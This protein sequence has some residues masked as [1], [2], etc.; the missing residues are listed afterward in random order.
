MFNYFQSVRS[1]SQVIG[2]IPV[3]DYL[4]KIRYGDEYLDKIIQAREVYNENKEIYNSIKTNELPCYTLN[5]TFDGTRKN[6]S[7][8][9]STGYVYLDIDGCTEFDF[10]NPIV[11]A[12]WKSLSNNGRGVLVKAEGIEP[13]NFRYAYKEIA[14]EIGIEA[15]IGANKASQPNVLSFDPNI[16]LN[17]NST[18]YELSYLGNEKNTHFSNNRIEKRTIGTETGSTFEH[19]RYDNLDELIQ[20][21]EYNDEVIY[22]YGCKIKYAD[23]YIPFG[24]FK[25]GGRNTG[26]CGYGYQLKN[27]NPNISMGVLL[28]ML[29]AANKKYCHP[30]LGYTQLSQIVKSI[31]NS[32]TVQPKFNKTRRFL[33][34]PDYDLSTREKRQLMAKKIGQDKIAKSKKKIEKAIR[35]WDFEKYGK[36]TQKGLTKTSGLNIKTVQKY[37]YL[38]KP[39]IQF[40]N[41]DY[42]NLT[43]L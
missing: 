24:G 19:L 10:S 32:V 42:S 16:Y 34:N 33:F 23:A 12:S 35:D 3:D 28:R 1:S 26:L 20:N 30:P 38:F 2:T 4:N 22:D 7:I 29:R 5:F 27:L 15:D 18:P 37:Y 40:L 36:I 21:V 25:K 43:L 8:K 13:D 9:E 14:E 11:F 6:S 41:Q 17:P 31:H 39:T